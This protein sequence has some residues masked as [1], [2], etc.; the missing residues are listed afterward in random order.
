MLLPD[1]PSNQDERRCLPPKPYSVFFPSALAFA[2]LALAA[3]ASFA[4]VAGLLRRSFLAGLGVAVVPFC[5]AHLALAAAEI[6]ALPALLI[7]LLPFAFPL[8]FILAKR[9]LRAFA[10]ALISLRLWEAVM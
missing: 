5:L 3:A 6:A 8:P 10:R 4:L 9:I 1:V 7:R 2:H